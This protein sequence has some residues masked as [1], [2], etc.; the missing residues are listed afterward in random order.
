MRIDRVALNGS[1]MSYFLVKA[2]QRGYKMEANENW[3]SEETS[4][5]ETYLEPTITEEK[6]MT[7]PIKKSSVPLKCPECQK[8]GFKDNRGLGVH[9]HAAHGVAGTSPSTLKYHEAKRD[10]VLTVTAPK[11]SHQK[12]VS[13]EVT[14]PGTIAMVVRTQPEIT[15]IPPAMLG[16]A[17][18]RL[19]SLAAQIARENML[20]EKEFIRRVAINF[21]ELTKR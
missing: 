11:K 7:A 9:R 6:A 19:E 8:T 5:K 3:F 10:S 4:K 17:M 13:G 18:G 14:A 12:K 1:E 21:A 16:Y 20:P 15:E 2:P